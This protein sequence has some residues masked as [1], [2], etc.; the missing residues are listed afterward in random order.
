MSLK[1]KVCIITGGNSGIGRGIA[2]KFAKEGAKVAI[3]GRTSATLQEVADEIQALGGQIDTFSLDVANYSAVENMVKTVSEKYGK[4][5]V[6]VNSAGGGALHKRTLTTTPEDMQQVLNSNLLGTIYFTQAVLPSMLQA[7]QGTIINISSGASRRPGLLGGM[8]YGVA[9]AGVN[10][11]TEFINSEF[12]NSGV[13]ACVVLPGEV[14]TP[15]LTRNR[16]VPVSQ[17]ARETILKPEDLAE[18]VAL[19]AEL[20]DRAHIQELVI[21]PTMR[22]D[23][24]AEVPPA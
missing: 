13:R 12:S 10:N 11:F 9:K 16:P 21:R 15:A 3:A 2:I 5:D 19:I 7:K 14:D 23:T 22:R 6:L 8:I 18:A 20:P 4:V 1:D 17:S 24:S